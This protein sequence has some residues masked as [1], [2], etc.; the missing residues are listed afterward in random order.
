MFKAGYGPTGGDPDETKE[1]NT[2]EKAHAWLDPII[3]EFPEGEYI[4]H[5]ADEEHEEPWTEYICSWQAFV[6]LVE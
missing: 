2:R 4:E 3:A 6:S 1:F 5:P